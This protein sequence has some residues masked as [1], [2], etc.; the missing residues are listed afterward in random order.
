MEKKVPG[1][2]V[3]PIYNNTD[4]FSVNY[5]QPAKTLDEVI[6]HLRQL[7]DDSI[8]ID[9]RIGYF[10]ALY[11]QMTIRVK[12]AIENG[13]FEDGKRMDKLDVIF[14]NRYLTAVRQWK[15]KQQPSG[16]WQIAFE[17]TKKSSP[18]VL[19]QLL[20]GI[21]AH[22]N[23]DLGIAAVETMED[24]D[25]HEIRKD[26]NNINTIIGSLVFEVLTQINRIS[27]LLSL[28]GMHAG[29][30]SI[31]IQFSITNARDGAW[32]FAEEL[33]SKKGVEFDACIK[34]RD[35]SIKKLAVSLSH[36]TGIL[37]FTRWIIRLFEWK[38]PRKIIKA[39]HTTKKEYI[40]S[41]TL[42]DL[43]KQYA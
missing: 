43:P 5:D 22:I 9:D 17:A 38:S 23:F 6:L 18:L 25:I 4:E 26:F 35:T 11:L 41:N 40:H 39:L 20:L 42:P 7:I 24:K 37:R 29:N 30:N 15:N 16:P 14:A 31:L 32:A 10:A 33:D 8:N 27:P 19:Q 34:E 2:R 3:I 21:N 13:E 1:T 36:P 12:E 28:F